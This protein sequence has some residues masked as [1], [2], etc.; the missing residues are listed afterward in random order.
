MNFCELPKAEIILKIYL[1]FDK[2][3]KFKLTNI[4]VDQLSYYSFKQ[5]N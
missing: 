5:N 1:P 3:N 2:N 4:I